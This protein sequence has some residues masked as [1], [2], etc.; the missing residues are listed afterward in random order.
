MSEELGEKPAEAV[1]VDTQVQQAQI[2]TI[3]D[4]AREQGWVPKEEFM[5]DEHKW[6]EPGEFIRRGELFKKIDQTTRHA[7]K[8]EQTL[9]QFKS[10]Y[11]KMQEIANKNAIETLKRERKEARDNGDFD[12]VDELEEQMEEVKANAAAAK[13]E[14]SA[15]TEV[16]EV[17]PEVAAWVERNDWYNKDMPMK[18]YADTV[19]MQLNKQGITGSALLKGIDAEVRKAFPAKF[20]NPNRERPSAV[21]GSTNKGGRAAEFELSEQETRIMNSFVRD[22]VMSKAEYIADLK[23]VKGIK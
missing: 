20:S 11:L 21:E 22:G 15:T 18:A 5:G 6:V 17:Y 8:V 14:I 3:E 9:E 19:A 4:Q 13:A 16:P 7:K 10:H 1:V 12:K 23:K 2:S